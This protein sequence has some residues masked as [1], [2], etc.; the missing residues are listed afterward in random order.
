VK[1]VGRFVDR[2]I[3]HLGS[4]GIGVGAVSVVIMIAM[5]FVHVIARRAF[6]IQFKVADEFGGYL[7]VIIVF[8]GF[9]YCLR[10]G[11]IINVELIFRRFPNK[12]KGLLEIVHGL[13]GILLV[14]IDLPL[15]IPQSVMLVGLSFF[16]LELLAYSVKK[17]A[18]F[19]E[20]IR[21]NENSYSSVNKWQ[22][23]E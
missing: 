18:A 7:L 1:E 23:R 20:I 22:I 10:K 15:W 9:A 16:M 4:F 21:K 13:L 5:I 3:G 6:D 14:A 11:K 8:M 2:F 12:I 17:F 19:S